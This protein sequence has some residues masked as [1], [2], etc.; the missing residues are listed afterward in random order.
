MPD[1]LPN[2]GHEPGPARAISARDR[3]AALALVLRLHG[4]VRSLRLYDPGHAALRAQLEELLRIVGEMDVDEV[5]VLG[6]GGY[7][8]VNGVRLRP[9]AAHLNVLRGL[10]EEFGIRG[11]GGLRFGRGLELDELQAFLRLFHADRTERAALDLPAA[12]ERD[13]LH[14]VAAVRARAGGSVSDAEG[15]MAAVA[16]ERRFTRLVFDR[17]VGGTSELLVRTARSGRPEMLHARRI[18]QPIVDQLLRQRTSLV[19][20]TAIK[21]HDDYAAV[22]CVNVSILAIRMGQF[23][24][25][26]RGELANLG[27]A[28]LLHDVGKVRVSADVLRKTAD[29]DAAEWALLRRHPIEGLRVIGRISVTSEL[30][31]D[32]MRVAFEHHMLVDHSGY[33]AVAAP[34][35]LGSFS[36]IV[37]VADLF[38]SLTAHRSAGSRPLTPHEALRAIM[39]ADDSRFDRAVRWA[40]VQALGL[41]PAGTLLMSWSGRMLL[42]VAPCVGDLARPVCRELVVD[43]DGAVSV[44]PEVSEAPLGPDDRIAQVLS[45]EDVAADV[46]DLLA[47]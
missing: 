31:V 46:E 40:M 17:A 16:D 35:E 5:S 2:P 6:L 39:S 3:E 29:L 20:L 9:E 19:G 13:G 4:V 37:A 41:Y 43:G 11:L 34:R 45:P 28:A 14:N 7:C 1:P 27:T 30:M 12:C 22:H 21:R 44:A 47:A 18:A 25:L 32:A 42:S 33:P 10:L 23:L 8:Y 26:S 36:R 24:G 38:D 15:E